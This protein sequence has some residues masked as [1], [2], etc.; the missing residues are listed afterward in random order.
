MLN[1]I[2]TSAI[3]A[4]VQKNGKFLLLQEHKYETIR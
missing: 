1:Y 2:N 4:K 3:A